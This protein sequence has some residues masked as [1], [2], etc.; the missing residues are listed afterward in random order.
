MFMNNYAF[1]FSM[2]GIVSEQKLLS[3]TKENC[4]LVKENN[5]RLA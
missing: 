1:A 5:Q 3:M 4:K 2:D